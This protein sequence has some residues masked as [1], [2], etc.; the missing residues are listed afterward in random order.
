MKIYLKIYMTDFIVL[1]T[2]TFPIL[3]IYTIKYVVC[4]ILYF[5]KYI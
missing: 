1:Y 4:I 3:R 5:L 2:E